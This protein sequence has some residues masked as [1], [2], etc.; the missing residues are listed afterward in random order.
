MY[1]IG[2][3]SGAHPAVRS[4]TPRLSTLLVDDSPT[5]LATMCKVLASNEHIEVIATAADGCEAVELAKLHRPRLVLMDVQMPRMNGITAT[6]LMN[7]EI[8]HAE[9]IIISLH[10]S[11]ELRALCLEAGARAF[12]PKER[13]IRELVPLIATIVTELT[14]D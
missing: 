6:S 12:I 9:V 7:R 14:A 4:G 8:P 5:A 3:N 10:D 11:P 13:L 2:P 1:W